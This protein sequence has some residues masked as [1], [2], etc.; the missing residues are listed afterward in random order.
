LYRYW[1]MAA[2]TTLPGWS[3]RSRRAPIGNRPC[4]AKE[5][6]PVADLVFVVVTVGLFV[7][8]ALVLWAVERL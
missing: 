3:N 4:R 6:L 7:V 1:C 5:E 2:L 8:L